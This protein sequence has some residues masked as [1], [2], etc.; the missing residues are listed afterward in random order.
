MV[1]LWKRLP[2]EPVDS[3]SLPLLKIQLYMALSNQTLLDRLGTRGMDQVIS[4]GLFHTK[5]LLWLYV[6]Q[7]ISCL[8]YI[9][10]DAQTQKEN[11]PWGCS[12]VKCCTVAANHVPLFL[13]TNTELCKGCSPQRNIRVRL[14]ATHLMKGWIL[15]TGFSCNPMNEALD[16]T[17]KIH[18]VF[19]QFWQTCRCCW[20]PPCFYNPTHF[21]NFIAPQ[22]QPHLKKRKYSH[23][24]S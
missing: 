23:Q 16:K 14:H 3:G 18:V 8:S 7:V 2:R 4:R 5:P 1:K 17:S 22:S 13:A 10:K 12:V 19:Y 21:L 6:T 11:M 15:L 9:W 20:L 24:Q